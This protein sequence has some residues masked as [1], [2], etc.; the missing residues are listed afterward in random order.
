[1]LNAIVMINCAVDSIP[2][3]AQK[4]ADLDGV[5]QVFSVTGDVDLIALVRVGEYDD[6]A[7]TVADSIAKVPGITTLRTHLAFRAYSRS[8]LEEA[9]Q[10]GLD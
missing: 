6:L 10:L 7:V 5:E 8:D 1:M 4:V 2:E 3:V 9:F